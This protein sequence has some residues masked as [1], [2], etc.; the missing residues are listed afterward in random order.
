MVNVVARIFA[1]LSVEPDL[2]RN[3]EWLQISIFFT[4]NLASMLLF[5]EETITLPD[6]TVIP[7]GAT[8]MIEDDG[9]YNPDFYGN[10]GNFDAARYLKMQLQPGAE[11][12]HQFVTTSEDNMGFGHGKHACPGRFFASNEI[13]IFFTFFLLRH[14]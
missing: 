14:D 5:A 11:N 6:G 8:L 2:C 9:P 1:R 10:P 12:R 3:D 7:Q 13:E 4:Q